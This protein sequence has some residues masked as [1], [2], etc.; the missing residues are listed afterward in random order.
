[1]AGVHCIPCLQ[2]EVEDDSLGNHHPGLAADV[3][4]VARAEESSPS[5]QAEEQKQKEEEASAPLP[6]VLRS[7]GSQWTSQDPIAV[8]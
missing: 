7:L 6:A 8:P 4:A 1:M 5:V 3:D 2:A